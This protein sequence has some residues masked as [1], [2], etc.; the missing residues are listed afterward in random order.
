MIN[1]NILTPNMRSN[2]FLSMHQNSPR[3]RQNSSII[4]SIYSKDTEISSS[5]IP[6]IMSEVVADIVFGPDGSDV[7][8]PRGKMLKN[9]S[10]WGISRAMVT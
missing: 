8:M 6:H 3:L 7:Y 1:S 4:C 2:L 9:R 5:F 10:G